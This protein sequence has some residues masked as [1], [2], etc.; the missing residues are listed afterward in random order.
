VSRAQALEAGPDGEKYITNAAKYLGVSA[1]DAIAGTKGYPF[2]ADSEQAGWLGGKL[3]Q[4]FKLTGQF[5]VSQG[6]AKT[7]P[8]DAEIARHIDA[9]FWAKAQQAGGCS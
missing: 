8:S 1:A 2:V 9:S 7:V 3:A 4:N 5:L 6:R